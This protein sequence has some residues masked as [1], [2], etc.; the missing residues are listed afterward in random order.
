[1]RVFHDQGTSD[2]FEGVTGRKVHITANPSNAVFN[3]QGVMGSGLLNEFKFGYNA[4]PTTIVGDAPLVNGVDFGLIAL[5]IT[6]SIANT[7]IA[8][9]GSS[10]GVAIPGGLVRANSATN[11]HASPY[12]PYSLTIGDTLTRVSRSPC[13]ESGCR[14][15]HHPHGDRSA[16][17]NDLRLRQRRRFMANNATTPST[18]ATSVTRASSTMARP[19]RGSSNRNTSS[20]SSRTSG[21]SAR[22]FTINFGLRYDYYTRWMNATSN[23][24][25]DID[26]GIIEPSTTPYYKS[27]KNNFQPRISADYAPTTKTVFRAG[28]GI[29]VGPGQTE[30]QIQP[31]ECGCDQDYGH[32]VRF[33][34]DLALLQANF[35]TNPNNRAYQPRAYANEYILPERI[36]QYTVSMQ[37]ELTGSLVA[38]AAYVGSQGRNLFLRSVAN[39]ITG[40]IQTSP[41]AAATVIREFS[42]VTNSTARSQHPEPIR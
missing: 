40:L 42:I 27:K 34:V 21:A 24:M 15:A 37:Q 11:G 19:A 1:M 38:T 14:G 9:Q 28:F 3:L 12:D 29:F 25:F 13:P 22:S 41:T 6:G 39:N 20:A 5:N 35:A 32:N 17:R 30:D 31:I 33:P 36:Y 16:R 26:T 7:G 23:V 4:A 18:W 2:Q 8:G 10:T